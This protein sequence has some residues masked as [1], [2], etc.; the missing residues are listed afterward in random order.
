MKVSRYKEEILNT[1]ADNP[2]HPTVNE[3]YALVRNKH[4]NIGMAT[5]YRNLDLLLKEGKVI[6]FH[7]EGNC[8]RYDANTFEHYHMKCN[9]CG[10]INDI[11]A[12]IVPKNILSILSEQ[13]GHN[14]ESYELTFT[15]VCTECN[16]KY[17]RGEK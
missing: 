3:L 14:I 8:E 9:Q 12:E 11:F 15:G 4:S 17:M 2:V 1:L 7:C 16:K 5:I 13:T 10:R 6:S